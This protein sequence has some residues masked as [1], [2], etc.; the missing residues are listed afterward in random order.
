MIF[1]VNCHINLVASPGCGSIL[2]M[3]KILLVVFILS[4]L[5]LVG[6]SLY[7]F[8]DKFDK[9]PSGLS[10]ESNPGS[11]VYLDGVELGPTPFSSQTIKAGTYVIKLVPDSPGTDP[12]PSWEKRFTLSPQ[13]TTVISR[14]FA[15]SE[16]DSSGFTLS[17]VPEKDGGTY[18]SVIS[19]PDTINISLDG[20]PQGFTP[21]SRLTTSSGTHTLVLSSPGFRDQELSVN[22]AEGYNLLV[23][24]KLALDALEIELP[25]PTP[26][27]SPSASASALPEVGEITKPY[28]VVKE[29]GTGWLRVRKDPSAYSDELGKANIGEKLKYLGENTETGW[30]KIEFEGEVGWTSG[31]YVEII[32]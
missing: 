6:T 29:T 12:L 17:Y 30:V 9:K 28:V 31:K 2:T 18:L 19:D 1:L 15:S 26:S 11:T 32:K 25:S 23:D 16:L 21:I 5:G 8:R 4:F 3:K 14:A 27:V 13:T 22:A 7:F 10:V 24:I 20:E